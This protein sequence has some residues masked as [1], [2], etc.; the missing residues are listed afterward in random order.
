METYAPKKHVI[1][2]PVFRG[3]T[4]GYQALYVIEQEDEWSDQT[5]R[6]I[7]DSGPWSDAMLPARSEGILWAKSKGYPLE[8]GF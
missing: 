3:P 5:F 1:L 8:P 2:A 4:G 7:L 6:T